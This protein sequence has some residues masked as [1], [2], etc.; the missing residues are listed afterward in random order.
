MKKLSA[1]FFITIFTFILTESIYAQKVI[2]LQEAISLAQDNNSDLENAKLDLLIA[3]TQVSQAYSENLIPD[4]K[5]NSTYTRAFKKPVFNIFGQNI[6]IGTDNTI[7]NKITVE[8]PIPILGTPVFQGIRIAEYYERLNEET[9]NSV[10][11]SVKQEVTEAYLNVLFAKEV[12]EVNLES[13]DN[14]SEN[15]Q[16]VEAQYKGG[17]ATEFDYLRAKVNME[18]IAPSID[19]AETNLEVSKLNLQQLMGMDETQPIEVVGKLTYDSVEVYGSTDSLV[20]SIVS[21]NVAIRQLKISQKINDELVSVQEKSYL[22]NLAVFGLYELTANEDDGVKLSDYRF[23]NTLSAGISLTW[24]LNLFRNSY[25]V[26]IKE[27]QARQNYETIEDTKRKLRTQA[28]SV[29]L[30]MN[31]AKKRIISQKENIMLA[32]RSLQLANYSFKD[33]VATQIDVLNS[34]LTLSQTKLNYLQ[35]IYDYLIA[36]SQLEELLAK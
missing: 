33:G 18:N 26:E 29:I 22:P 34:E 19:A 17:V 3:K 13:M 28:Y 35:A 10:E 25:E 20:N 31:D 21:N 5:L 12:L 6:T 23:F 11:A 9:V 4:I 32:E 36:K 16:V 7:S 14:A 27:L 30:N 2:T 15:Y 8:E 1:V 24:D